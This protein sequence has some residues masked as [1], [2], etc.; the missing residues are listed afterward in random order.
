MGRRLGNGEGVNELGRKASVETG[1]GSSCAD[2]ELEG[3]GRQ[4][5]WQRGLVSESDDAVGRR[6]VMV[7]WSGQ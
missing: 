1:S 6:W 5:G 2:L 7:R 3:K 4:K